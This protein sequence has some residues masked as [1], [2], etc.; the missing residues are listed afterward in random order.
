MIQY[1]KQAAHHPDW[2]WQTPAGFRDEPFVLNF[3]LPG[4]VADGATTHY[5]LPVQ[6]E[7]DADFLVRSLLL[8]QIGLAPRGSAIGGSGVNSPGRVRITTSN[9]QQLSRDLVLYAGIWGGAGMANLLA[10][11]GSMVD[12]LPVPAGGALL[13]DVLLATTGQPA[14]ASTTVNDTTLLV[15][16]N[17]FGAAGNGRTITIIDPGAPNSPLS[18]VMAGNNATISL[19]TDALGA[20]STTFFLLA[21]FINSNASLEPLYVAEVSGVPVEEIVAPDVLNFVGGTAGGLVD[22]AGAFVGVKRYKAC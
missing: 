16:A 6:V 17:V 13:L 9:G 18:V 21:Q 10:A 4:L 1:S 2:A 11:G 7:D 19:Q 15:Y 12:P 14:S 8:P 5:G 3:L 22:L 20:I